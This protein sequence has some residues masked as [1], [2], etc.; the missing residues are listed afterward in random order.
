[1]T[2]RIYKLAF[3]GHVD[4]G[5]SS[6]I[7]RLLLD[8]GTVSRD[9]LDELT[10][11][12]GTS[13]AIDPA[14]VT[15]CLEEERARAVTIDTAEARFATHGREYAI[16][17]TPGHREFLKNMVTGASR[18][19]AAVLVIDV[20]LGVE[21]QTRRHVS[22]LR[23]IG[24]RQ[25]IV[26]AN[27]M[28]LAG[29]KADTFD[30]LRDD[31][32]ELL[33]DFE[34]VA[35]APVSARVGDNVARRSERTPWY[36]GATLLDAMARL[37]TPELPADLPLRLPVQGARTNPGGSVLVFGRIESG[38]LSS[39][40]E[41][42]FCPSG[43]RTSIVSI[44]QS[45]GRESTDAAAGMSVGVVVADSVL[46]PPGEVICHVAS[47]VISARRLS[48]NVF[49]LGKEPLCAGV[50]LT[51]RC[52]SQVVECVISDVRPAAEESGNG[53]C[54]AD[55]QLGA[56]DVR[57]ASPL[58]ADTFDSIPPL[59][60]LAFSRDGRL[61]AAGVIASLDKSAAP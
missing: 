31:I 5:K 2:D 44:M 54:L 29:Y 4:H 6:L 42:V 40:D 26:A 22:V 1:V 11:A 37:D 30:A 3:T 12:A 10:A 57:T 32:A 49:W 45:S 39:G 55:G 56:V 25:V 18:A 24:I 13:G 33:D 23:M 28:D 51:A 50:R 35:I 61:V 53:A 43:V 47:P 27:K 16:I 38:R 8:T 60:R 21:A 19:D 59:G 41:V 36:E 17:D 52:A 9:R 14:F 34:V 48:A 58:S 7:G 15:D 46:P 20:T